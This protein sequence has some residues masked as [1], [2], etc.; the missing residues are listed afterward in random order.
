MTSI[1]TVIIELTF[2]CGAD[3]RMGG[4]GGGYKVNKEMG[5]TKTLKFCGRPLWTTHNVSTKN[6]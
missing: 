1:I 5:D 3:I 2:T 4:G 6:I